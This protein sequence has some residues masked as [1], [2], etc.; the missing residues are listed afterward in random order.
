MMVA[1]SRV[2]VSEIVFA[3]PSRRAQTLKP[4]GRLNVSCASNGRQ[5]RPLGFVEEDNSG[6]ANIFGVEPKTLYVSSPR[7]DRVSS[8]GIGGSQ[9]LGVVLGLIAAVAVATVVV[10]FQPDE[11][12]GADS[13]REGI[14]R[15]QDIANGF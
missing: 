9:G 8:Q 1:L 2:G 13:I 5:R 10:G 14:V 12:N 4:F 15:L 7:S 3:S 11:G 6:K